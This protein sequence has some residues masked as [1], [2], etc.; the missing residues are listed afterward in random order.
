MPC[1]DT[2][3]KIIS[4]TGVAHQ[5]THRVTDSLRFSDDRPADAAGRSDYQHA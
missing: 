5:R 3:G 2:V 4:V 1:V